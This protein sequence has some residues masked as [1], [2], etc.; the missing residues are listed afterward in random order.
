MK[1]SLNSVGEELDT[2][3]LSNMEEEE[4][5]VDMEELSVIEK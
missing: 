1:N 5:D 2:L 4:E 3:F